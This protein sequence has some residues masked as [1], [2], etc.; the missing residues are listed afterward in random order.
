MGTFFASYP[1]LTASANPS[2]GPNGQ[3]I[4]GDSTLVAGENPSGDQQPLQTDAAGNL[5]VNIATEPGTP[6]AVNLTEVSGA[7]IT[8]GSKTSANSLPVV[9][10]S[11]DTVAISAVS[12]P[13]PTNASTSALQ[14]NVQSAPGTPQTVAVT[15]Q[16]NSSG[17]AVPVSISGGFPT[18]Q[19]VNV[20]QYGGVATTLGSKI[21]ASSIPVVIA[22]DQANVAV[23]QG[24]ASALNATVVQATGTNLHVVTDATSTTIATQATASNLNAAVVGTG[25]AGTPNAGVVT[26]QGI[27]SGTNVNVNIAAGS[28]TNLST[29]VAQFGGSAVV[30]GTGASGAGIPRVTVS[31]DSNVI[32]SQG[33]AA[34]LNATVVQATATNLNAAVVGVGAAGTPS[35]GV[36]TVQGSSSGTAIPTTISTPTAGAITQAA[37]SVGTTAVRTT[38]SGSA[39]SATRKLLVVTPD[40]ASTATFYIG[41]SSVTSTSTTRGPAIVAGQSFIA[42]NDAGDYYIVASIAGQTFETMEQ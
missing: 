25:S 38:V 29:N 9:I 37:I 3:P 4:P 16:G 42:N 17:I 14:S 19:N 33:T 10:A 1:S 5:L 34:N 11:D 31:N 20:N 8:L 27:T 13:L 7:A 32:V 2:V 36:L 35:G 30:T 23:S 15:I 41:S 24:T 6:L 12:L 26:V 39:P 22:S 40:P 28:V 21:S 18:E